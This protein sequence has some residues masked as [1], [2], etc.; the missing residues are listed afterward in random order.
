NPE[1]LKITFD[2]APSDL[3]SKLMQGSEEKYRFS[4]TFQVR[5]VMIATGEPPSFSTVVGVDQT[6]EPP[7]EIGE[8]GIELP[9]LPSLGPTIERVA[10]GRFEAGDSLVVTGGDL[11]LSGLSVRLGPAE[12]PVTAQRPG[13]LRCEVD[14]DVAAGG[15]IS[16]GGHALAVVQTLPDG[17]RRSSNLLVGELRPTLDTAAVLST[18]HPPPPDDGLV[19]GEVL[20]SGALLG[21]EDDDVV[22]A[23]YRDGAVVALLDGE[24]TFAT[25]QATLQLTIADEDAVDPG[26]YRV[27]LRVNGQQAKR[28]PAIEL[29]V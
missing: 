27:I 15:V 1:P 23:L 16:A 19:A 7:V 29:V 22:V 28:S 25:D 17:R 3:L 5:P 11:A 13:R 18:H 20:L 26:T 4:M 12:L 24:F 10:P 8:E 2:E 14:G 21:R 6:E 9:V